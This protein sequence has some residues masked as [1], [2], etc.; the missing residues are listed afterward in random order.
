MLVVAQAGGER[1]RLALQVE[2][3]ALGLMERQASVRAAVEASQ[4]HIMQ[5][6]EKNYKKYVRYAVGQRLALL[7]QVRSSSSHRR[8]LQ[9]FRALVATS[10]CHRH[11]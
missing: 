1:R 6:S 7:K 10:T 11:M 2:L 8:R 9:G 4:D 3:R 5:M